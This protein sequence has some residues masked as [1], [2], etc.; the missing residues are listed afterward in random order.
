MKGYKGTDKDMKCRGFQY[1]LDKIFIV[2]DDIKLCRNGIHFCKNLK[3][4]FQFYR[5][6]DEN[7]FFEVEAAGVVKGDGKKFVASKVR[8]IRELSSI[9]VNRIFY[10]NGY[11]DGSGNAYSYGFGN[12]SGDGY[13]CNTIFDFGYGDGNSYGNGNGN[14]CCYNYY[15]NGGSCDNDI[16][17]TIKFL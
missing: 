12:G 8:F 7:R 5:N 9:E 4:V 3:D 13:N 2:D 15:G 16:Y 6:D 11:T 1:E 17:K 14:G 10:N